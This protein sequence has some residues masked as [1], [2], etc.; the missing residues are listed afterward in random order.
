MN[1]LHSFRHLALAIAALTILG[2]GYRVSAAH[3]VPFKGRADV[4]LTSFVPPLT[5]IGTGKATHLG[6]FTRTETINPNPD[7]TF[8]GKIE[9]IADNGDKLCADFR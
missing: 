5:A 6:P 8:T 1:L 3:A 7:G 4:V 2:I 9:F